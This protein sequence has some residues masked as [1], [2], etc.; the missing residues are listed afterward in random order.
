MLVKDLTIDEFKKKIEEKIGEKITEDEAKTFYNQER[1]YNVEIAL[2][3]IIILRK[4]IKKLNVVAC[5]A[6]TQWKRNYLIAYDEKTNEVLTLTG[7]IEKYLISPEKKPGDRLEITGLE[8]Q[9]MFYVE[10][11]RKIGETPITVFESDPERIVNTGILLLT[12]SI[13][14]DYPVNWATWSK[15]LPPDKW[16]RADIYQEGTFNF[17]IFN[18]RGDQKITLYFSGVPTEFFSGIILPPE[19][20]EILTTGEIETKLDPFVREEVLAV[21]V[22]RREPQKTVPTGSGVVI[23]SHK[24]NAHGMFLIF[25]NITRQ[26]TISLTINEPAQIKERKEEKK[27]KIKEEPIEKE[28]K[29]DFLEKFKQFKKPISAILASKNLEDI[30]AF[31]LQKC[32]EKLLNSAGENFEGEIS[33]LVFTKN[34]LDCGISNEDIQILLLELINSNLIYINREGYCKIVK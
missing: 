27:E 29:S 26:E 25:K 30:G 14:V 1:I 33:E 4:M 5:G 9:G 6:F 15:D 20:G 21:D 17:S 7:N 31:K 10:T 12:G 19:K 3:R 34:A 23:T 13:R 24:F 11:L 2:H 8:K 22:W 16:E 18:D 32:I 28:S